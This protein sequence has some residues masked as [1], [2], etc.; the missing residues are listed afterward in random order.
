MSDRFCEALALATQLHRG[1]RR[2]GNGNPY[3][4]HLLGVAALVMEAGGD[5]DECIAALLHDAVEDQGGAPTARL[6]RRRFGSRVAQVVEEC[7]EDRSVPQ[8]WRDRKSASVRR[9]ANLTPSALLVLSADKLHNAR[10]LTAAHRE[11][12][13]AVWHRFHG[14]RDGTL[15]YYRAMVD[16]IAAAGG[17]PLARELEKA[18]RDLER[19][20]R[21]GEPVS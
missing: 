21:V 15:W 5:E 19:T 12:G 3:L 7:T 17:G 1:Q 20:V 9:V 14:G 18:V 8:S 11:A 16:A 10:S 6:I 4:S 13:S 2:K